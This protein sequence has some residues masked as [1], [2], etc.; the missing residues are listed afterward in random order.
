MKALIIPT[1]VYPV[2]PLNSAPITGVLDL[3]RVLNKALKFVFNAR[4]PDLV[5]MRELHTR[6]KLKPINQILHNRAKATWD[7]IESGTAGDPD[8]FNR[9]K[10]IP[11]VKPHFNFPSSY[12]RTLKEE[13]PPIYTK[14]DIYLIEV[15]NYYRN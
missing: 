9:I 6:A 1:L 15:Q 12:R 11:I 14:E 7:K 10:R 2:T 5:T 8:M 4:Y 13:P 3:Q